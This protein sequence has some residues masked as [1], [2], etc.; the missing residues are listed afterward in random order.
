MDD[1]LGALIAGEECDV[2]LQGDRHKAISIALKQRKRHVPRHTMQPFTSVE[3]LLR[4]AF[5]SA[6]HTYYSQVS[7]KHAK[8]DN[9]H[10]IKPD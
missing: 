6:W 3:F 5:I 8:D 2:D 1:E 7:D 4:I 9:F 10:T